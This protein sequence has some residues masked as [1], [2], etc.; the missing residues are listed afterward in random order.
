MTNK[1]TIYELRKIILKHENHMSLFLLLLVFYSEHPHAHDFSSLLTKEN[2]FIEIF[3]KGAI[4][5]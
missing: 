5:L 1:Q 2:G 3:I 4:E